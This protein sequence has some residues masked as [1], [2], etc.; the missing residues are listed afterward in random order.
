VRRRGRI[1]LGAGLGVACALALAL[2]G[3]GADMSE[4]DLFLLTR[5][6]QGPGL[7]LLAN[8]SGTIRCNG[9]RTR[10]LSDPRLIQ[11]RDLADDL[12]PLASRDLTIP[13]A[14]GEVG[15]YTIRMQQGTIR[16]P[17]IAARARKP[18]AEAELFAVQ[19]G[20]ACG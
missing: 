20:W 11:A 9:G 18:L 14:R 5:T 2:A 16:F 7:K 4:P 10:T 8:S 19:M 17:D 12:G 1:A 13:P 15:Y 3:C 6:G